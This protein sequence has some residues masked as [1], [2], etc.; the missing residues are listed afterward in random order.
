MFGVL[1]GLAAKG[2]AERAYLAVHRRDGATGH[3]QFD[4]MSPQALRGRIAPVLFKVAVPFL[5][6]P[7]VGISAPTAQ[8]VAPFSVADELK[9]L[10]AL[11]ET[12]VL[13]EEEFVAQKARV[14]GS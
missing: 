6:E 8:G 10:V 5:D 14:L 3:F 1:G 2:S 4:K 12:G 7:P 13:T 9:K 11:R